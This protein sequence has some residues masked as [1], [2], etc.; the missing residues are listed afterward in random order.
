VG[1]SG[2]VRRLVGFVRRLV[3]FVRRLVGFVRRLV[4]FVRSLVGGDGI[5][6]SSV[7]KNSSAVVGTPLIIRTIHHRVVD[8]LEDGGESAFEA[9]R[10][11]AP[12]LSDA[13]A[14]HL[15]IA[16]VRPSNTRA[17]SSILVWRREVHKGGGCERERVREHAF[18]IL[19][20]CLHTSARTARAFVGS[21]VD[22]ARH[23]VHFDHPLSEA[24]HGTWRC[25]ALEQRRRAHDDAH[26]LALTKAHPHAWVQ[27]FSM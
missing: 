14:A 4:G 24:A 2:T 1:V 9:E 3:G 17:I 20:T 18:I 8:A 26:C 19:R 21:G 25:G 6:S 23:Q 13:N 15:D 16:S 7:G 10:I 12:T 5:E 27:V 11:R 22:D